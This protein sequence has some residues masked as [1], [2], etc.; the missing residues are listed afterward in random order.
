MTVAIGLL[1]A[2][3]VIV[4]SDSMGSAGLRAARAQK[5]HALPRLPVVWTAAGAVYTIEEGDQALLGLEEQVL[6][7]EDG[8]A[9]F[10]TPSLPVIRKNIGDF[11]RQNMAQ[12]YGNLIPARQMQPGLSHP[13]SADFLVLG[14]AAGGPW[15]L[16]VAGDG[17]MNW[18]TAAKFYAVG[19]GG[20]FASVCQAVM[21]HYFEGELDVHV[22]LQVAYRSIEATC[23]VSSA[24]V[25]L[26][27]QLAVAD[28]QGARVLTKEEGDEVGT[29][30]ERWMISERA[31][32][33]DLRGGKVVELRAEEPL[34]TLTEPDG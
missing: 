26:P 18:H 2:D 8:R 27:V 3:G 25:G 7:I 31:I 23:R 11:L 24:G 20:D 6:Q 17:Q 33:E 32:V 28:A 30:V 19:S 13:F 14:W 5:V 21:A 34:P 15:L 1:C 10:D 22:G 12:C 4:A 16:E 9:M 29:A